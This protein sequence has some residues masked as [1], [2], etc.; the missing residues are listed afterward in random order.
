MTVS[1]AENYIKRLQPF[2]GQKLL[3]VEGNGKNREEFEVV[4]EK[5]YPQ[6]G[7]GRIEDDSHAS[8]N[9][10]FSYHHLLTEETK[11]YREVE[12]EFERVNI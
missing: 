3:F 10:S 12:D 1:N 5:V 4:L 8:Y 7:M 6:L 11:I 9:Y 2:V